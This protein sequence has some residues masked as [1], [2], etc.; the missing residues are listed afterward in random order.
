MAEWSK[1]LGSGP[2]LQ[3][4]GF[5]SHSHQINFYFIQYLYNNS[6]QHYVNIDNSFDSI[7][8]YPCII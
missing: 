2:S 1:A 8:N 7:F 5:E 3:G 6:I 4:R